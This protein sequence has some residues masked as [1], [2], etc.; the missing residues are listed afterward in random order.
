MPPKAMASSVLETAER[1]AEVR[2]ILIVAQQQG[3][4]RRV[5]KLRAASIAKPAILRVELR[6]QRIAS[7]CY[8]CAG[9]DRCRDIAGMADC[10]RRIA[11][12]TFSATPST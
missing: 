6:Q 11:V 3:K 7:L 4:A 2:L 5:G 9:I 12:I 8:P 1:A 10:T